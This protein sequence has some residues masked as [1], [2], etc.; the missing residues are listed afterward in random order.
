[1]SVNRDEQQLTERKSKVKERFRSVQKERPRG[2]DPKKEGMN[3]KVIEMWVKETLADAETSEIPG[4]ISTKE[5]KDHL[6]RYGI[7]R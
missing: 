1:M 7:D 5:Y 2:S 3:A 6:Q 4:T